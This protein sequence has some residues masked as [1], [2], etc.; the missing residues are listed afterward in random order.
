MN[1]NDTNSMWQNTRVG[2]MPRMNA[3]AVSTGL[4]YSGIGL[5]SPIP[6]PVQKKEVQDMILELLEQKRRLPAAQSM[7]DR[8]IDEGVRDWIEQ[9]KKQRA[10]RTETKWPETMDEIFSKPAGAATA[11]GGIIPLVEKT[12]KVYNGNGFTNS[13]SATQNSTPELYANHTGYIPNSAK[14]F[15]LE[16]GTVSDDVKTLQRWLNTLGYTD[17]N[18]RP[19][20]EDGEFGQ[21]TLAAV[22]N[23]KDAVLPGG[24]TDVNRGV[25]GPTTWDAM[26]KEVGHKQRKEARL[27]GAA[28][29]ISTAISV[30]NAADIWMDADTQI[31]QYPD[32][33]VF[34]SDRPLG[35]NQYKETAP[36]MM[37]NNYSK[38]ALIA[39][40]PRF[41]AELDKDPV[42]LFAIFEKMA[43][44]FSNGELE[45]VVLDMIDHFRNG[46]GEPY[47]NKVLTE[48]VK[49]HS[50]TKKYT[51]TVKDAVI[52]ELIKNNGDLSSLQ[53]KN[54]SALD[55]YIQ[56]NARYP[57]FNLLGDNIQGLRIAIND[58]W[59][60]SVQIKDYTLNKNGFSGVLRFRIYDHFGLDSEDIK[61]FGNLQG[62]RAWYVLQKY[63]GFDGKY[64]PFPT[65]IEFDIPF[66]GELS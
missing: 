34:Q 61:K 14:D 47:Q 51:D 39:L 49:R 22:N 7:N 9:D 11:N 57:A 33:L 59:G 36:D 60:N 63:S 18:G 28:N 24:N 38:D 52:K 32:T 48:Y 35:Y 8:L 66:E 17:E 54:G 16:L 45:S 56:N 50:S 40:D 62:F 10:T 44:R 53:F 43:N 31:Q 15:R 4:P 29:P 5:T 12:G 21:H 13:V 30:P 26:F 19:L 2:R 46:N 27:E 55:K 6:E 64:K 65:V 25:V 37:F 20:V 42:A 58:T 23:F 41:K 3:A 1:T